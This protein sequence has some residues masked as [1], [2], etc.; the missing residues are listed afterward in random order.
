MVFEPEWVLT[1]ITCY[2]LYHPI[3]WKSIFCA[4]RIY[5]SCQ[6][7]SKNRKFRFQEGVMQVIFEKTIHIQFRRPA[8]CRS[9]KPAQIFYNLLLFIIEY[10][11]IY[12]IWPLYY[13][14]VTLMVFEKKIT[15]LTFHSTKEVKKVGYVKSISNIFSKTQV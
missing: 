2:A 3:F 1:Y 11:C 12:M 5:G 7:Y 15:R 13:A 10:R 6:W 4:F 14:W 8:S 9:A